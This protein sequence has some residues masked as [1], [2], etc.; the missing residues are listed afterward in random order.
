MF[1]QVEKT[2]FAYETVV[3]LKVTNDEL[4]SDYRKAMTPILTKYEGGFRYDFKILETL[5]S[6]DQKPINR[7]FLIYFNN[8]ESKDRFFKDPEYIKIKE[9]FFTPSVESNTIISEYERYQ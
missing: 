1:N 4:Y 3:G 6:E 8:K 7:L 2:A 9:T 5:I